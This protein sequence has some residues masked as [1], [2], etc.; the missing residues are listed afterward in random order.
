MSERKLVVIGGDAAGMSA[1]SKVRREH[2]NREIVV[3]ERGQHTSFSACGMPYMIA[4]MVDSPDD[5][6]ARKPEVFR[7]KQ[8][9][10]VRI[11]HEVTMIDTA[12]KRVRV[13]NLADGSEFYE[14]YDDLLIATGA[15]PV[16]PDMQGIG[17]EGVFGLSILQ[18]GIAV[19]EYI[20][21]QN[22]QKA[23]IV[24]GGYIGIEMAEALLTQDM[25]VSLIDMAPE[26]MITMDPDMGKLISE[27]MREQGVHLYLEEKLDHF[28]SENGRVTGV[29]TSKR[30]LDADLVILGM[31]VRPNS[32]LAEKAGIE[33]GENGA[34]RVNKRMETSAAHIWAAGD[35]AESFHLISRRQVHIALGTVANKHG[36]IAGINISGGNEEFPGVTGTAITKMNGLEI[37]RT[38]LNE[39]EAD[40][41]GIPF[42]STVIKS[43]TRSGYFPGS[44]DITV[45]LLASKKDNRLLGGQIV[46]AEGAAKRIDTIV[47]AITSGLT[48]RDLAYMDLAYAPPFSPVW[49]PVQTAARQLIVAV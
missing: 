40:E 20:R 3:F 43:K 24:G 16:R 26:V 33:T 35:C 1:A 49:D 8:N 27:Y 46:G 44:G 15:S 10:D 36:L 41:A 23:V 17:S 13:C 34:I 11:R 22:P 32:G 5:L 48:A 19:F 9:I 29:V 12:N 18:T 2:K 38:G 47:T 28:R 31:G 4:G 45:K 37:A 39:K 21:Q 7:E 6:I 25:D 30:T 14:G 42:E